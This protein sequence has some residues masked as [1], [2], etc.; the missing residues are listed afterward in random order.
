MITEILLPFFRSQDDKKKSF[1]FIYFCIFLISIPCFSDGQQQQDPLRLNGGSILAMSGENCVALAVDMRLG[2]G[3]QMVHTIPRTVLAPNSR[4]MV[5]FTG[6]EG[7]VQS[8]CSQLSVAMEDKIGRFGFFAG[9][10]TYDVDN[11]QHRFNISPKSTSRLISHLLYGRR[12]SRPF[13]VEP[14]TVGLEAVINVESNDDNENA[15]FPNDKESTRQYKPFL[16]SHDIIGAKSTSD[17]FVCSG[18][19]SKSLYGTAEALWRPGLQPEELAQV[20]GKAFLSALERDCLSGYG[21]VVYLVIGGV[22]ITQYDLACR[23]D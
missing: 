11:E 1:K 15:E 3:P 4:V 19:A 16:C 10:E 14:I 2:N 17:S 20:C 7:D 23:N 12:N 8:F 13:Y 18:A 21:A 6:L 22:G 5:G 9:D